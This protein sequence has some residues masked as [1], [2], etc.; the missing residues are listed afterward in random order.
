[1]NRRSARTAFFGG[2]ARQFSLHREPAIHKTHAERSSPSPLSWLLAPVLPSSS[3]SPMSAEA[4]DEKKSPV[5][6]IRDEKQHPIAA[7]PAA[8][9]TDD[10]KAIADVN[11]K[12]SNPLAGMSHEQLMHDGAE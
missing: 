2:L 10:D 3:S 9:P 5:P 6:S 7:V 4:S 11:A 12:L 1:M 8:A